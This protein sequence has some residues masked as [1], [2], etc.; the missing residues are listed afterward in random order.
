MDTLNL[1]VTYRP[2]RIGWCV[3]DGNME[4]VR[5]AL[6]L[7]HTLWGGRYNPIIP[8]RDR[9]HLEIFVR[10]FRVDVLC[11]A[12]EARELIDIAQCL[13]YLR[14]PGYFRSPSFL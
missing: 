8:A 10:K 5:R 4:D 14:W 12:A 7:T 2:V 13:P 1:R 11:P 3:R 6:S 9:A